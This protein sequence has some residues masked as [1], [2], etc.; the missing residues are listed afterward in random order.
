MSKI[1][2]VNGEDGVVWHAA[3]VATDYDTLCGIDASDPAIGHFGTL[4]SSRRDK[5]NCAACKAIFEGFRRLGL[6]ATDFAKEGDLI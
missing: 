4:P 3:G 6:R 5:I 1:V 2:G